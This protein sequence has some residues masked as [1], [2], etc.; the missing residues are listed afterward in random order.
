M[1]AHCTNNATAA[2]QHST[3]LP[4]VSPFRQL[5]V[6]RRLIVDVR[7]RGVLL[8]AFYWILLIRRVC[9]RN[10]QRSSFDIL[11]LRFFHFDESF[12][13]SIGTYLESLPDILFGHSIGV[14]LRGRL[15]VII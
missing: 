4:I 13:A 7:L 9:R 15:V 11:L 2:D 5:V 3:S 8:D 10:A 14:D 6:R 12:L 1:D